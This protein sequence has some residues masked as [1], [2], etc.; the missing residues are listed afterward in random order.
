MAHGTDLDWTNFLTALALT[1][2][3]LS[4]MVVFAPF[5]SSTALPLRTKAVFVGAVA[6]P[7]RLRQRFAP[8]TTSSLKNT[9]PSSMR[10]SKR[11]RWSLP[12]PGPYSTRASS[13]AAASFAS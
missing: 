4:G 10:I 13:L 5:F 7:M 3:R 6:Y 2:L 11:S 1:L 12:G 9:P 8:P